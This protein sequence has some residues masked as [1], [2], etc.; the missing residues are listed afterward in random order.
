MRLPGLDIRERHIGPIATVS[1]RGPLNSLS[2]G[3]T[4]SH[5]NPTNPGPGG[6]SRQAARHRFADKVG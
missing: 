2:E 6:V 1:G 3:P 4:R 5:K